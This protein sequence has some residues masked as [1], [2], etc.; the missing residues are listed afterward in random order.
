MV[1]KTHL[2][3]VVGSPGDVNEERDLLDDV[4]NRIN[5]HIANPKGMHLDLTKWEKDL[6]K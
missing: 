1:D 4:I 6:R 3:V 5:T 2:R